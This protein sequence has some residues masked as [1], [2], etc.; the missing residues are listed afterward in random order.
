M[1]NRTPLYDSH[2]RAG[3]K[4]VDFGGWDMPLHYGSQLDEHHLVRTAAGMFDVSH[5]TI[6]D[7]KGEQTRAFLRYLVANNVDKLKKP[8]KALYTCMLNERG[9]VID[10][11]I[12]YYVD[13]QWFRLVVNAATRDKDLAWIEGQAANFGIAVRERR[14][15]AMIAVQGPA[16]RD[17]VHSAMP[18][19]A[20][21]AAAL[22]A[23]FTFAAVGE[24]F[25]ARTGYT[26]EDGY[27]LMVP[28]AQAAEVWQRFAAAGVEPA[29]LGARDT[30]RL[31]A[32]MNLYGADMD[33]TTTPLESGLAWTVGWEP[34]D[35]DFIG[36]AVLDAQRGKPDVARFI[37]LVMTDKG[38]L[39]NHQKV[40]AKGEVIGEITSGSFSPTLGKAIALARVH[41]D[42]GATC[43]VEVRGKAVD[44]KV[45][46]PPF[47]RNGK[48]CVEV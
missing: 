8:G 22:A 37:G 17:K 38:V 2:V 15:L 28:A 33:E 1:G 26:G 32:G 45:V 40:M 5:M 48:A 4:I 11:L 23:P 36:R 6:V 29:G 43:Q 7:L 46:K 25:I 9:G 10:D 21:A 30:L 44:V 18:D 47:V 14:D 16:A 13:D 19:I 20:E 3:A 35:R 24:L 31:E 12:I 39:R 42:P 27:E 34:A 41:G